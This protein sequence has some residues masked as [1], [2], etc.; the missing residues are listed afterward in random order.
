[1]VCWAMVTCIGMC[2]KLPLPSADACSFAFQILPSDR[3]LDLRP[4]A[5]CSAL[6]MSWHLSKASRHAMRPPGKWLQRCFGSAVIPPR[7]FSNMG[8][9]PLDASLLYEEETLRSFKRSAYYPAHM[10][11]IF[12]DRYQIVA[13][14]GYGTTSTVW[15]SRDLVTSDFHCLKVFTRAKTLS[16]TRELQMSKDIGA[17]NTD[18]PG[19]HAIRELQH[20]FRVEADGSEHTCALF[21]PLGTSLEKLKKLCPGNVIPADILRV[22]TKE[23]LIALD[24]LHT[25]AQ[26]V[27]TDLLP[28]N[29]ICRAKD[30]DVFY[31]M[32][33]SEHTE[34]T[35]RKTSD[36]YTVYLSRMVPFSIDSIV[37]TD[38]GEAEGV[39]QKLTRDIMSD[40]FRAPEV[41]LGH[42]WGYAVDIW[43]LGF[44]LWH[45]SHNSDLF[46]MKKA[47][48]GHPCNTHHL[49]QMIALLG[50]PP[51]EFLHRPSYPNNRSQH[52]REISGE[53]EE[54]L[55]NIDKK[56]LEDMEDQFEAEEKKKFLAFLRRALTW[57]PKKRPTAIEL[58]RDEWI[59]RP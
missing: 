54:C 44:L 53:I 17:I 42:E 40:A 30:P 57:D 55:S 38:F 59:F 50:R 6:D 22:I 4:T 58:L 1:M 47:P 28:D 25:E 39:R 48:L 49:A 11:E 43:A 29:L 16:G 15:L 5:K 45:L 9:Q 10:G 12:Q 36:N 32:E 33:E 46:C 3:A 34:P 31:Q 37:L 18:H 20:T 7:V 14:L 41:I 26:I 21:E 24:F 13:K 8:A 35:P 27:H 23:V 2:S 56:S 52:Y 51:A 19:K